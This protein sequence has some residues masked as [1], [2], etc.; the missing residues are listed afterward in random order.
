MC[1]D[2]FKVVFFAVSKMQLWL[3]K[4]SIS[5]GLYE[6]HTLGAIRAAMIN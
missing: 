2:D 1:K 5:K 4:V 6:V 3:L